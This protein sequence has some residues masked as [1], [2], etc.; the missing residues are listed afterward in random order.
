MNFYAKTKN[1]LSRKCDTSG[2]SYLA[3]AEAYFKL[4]FT[5]L[6]L[7]YITNKTYGENGN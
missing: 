1:D 6:A 4:Y 3:L 5:S 2:P 7:Q